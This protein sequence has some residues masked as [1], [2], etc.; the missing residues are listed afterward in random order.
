MPRSLKR[1]LAKR[2]GCL[3]VWTQLLEAELPLSEMPTPPCESQ[4]SPP[5][6]LPRT[7]QM[8]HLLGVLA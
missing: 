2:A 8:G 7:E 1:I 4:G 6:D 3:G 5:E